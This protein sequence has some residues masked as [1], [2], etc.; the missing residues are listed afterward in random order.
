MFPN[1]CRSYG[2]NALTA[3]NTVPRQQNYTIFNKKFLWQ[4]QLRGCITITGDRDD[5]NTRYSSSFGGVHPYG[6]RPGYE[7]N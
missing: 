5:K 6:C 2:E 3:F 1:K 4:V 7:E